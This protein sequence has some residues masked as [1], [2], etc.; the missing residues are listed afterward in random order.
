MLS[1][2]SKSILATLAYFD[3]FDYPL[4]LGELHRN[5]FFPQAKKAELPDIL[6]LE[7][8]QKRLNRYIDSVD[9]FYFLRGRT[10]ISALRLARYGLAIK[11]MKRAKLFAKLIA[12]MPYVRGIALSNNLAYQNASERSDIDLMII[13][14]PGR[15]WTA[16]FFVKSLMNA[17]K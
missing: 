11:K 2:V 8:A 4:T 12:A 14:A 7:S 16:R 13:A 1:N 17:G 9:G 15:V 10:E 6:E 3:I 5:L